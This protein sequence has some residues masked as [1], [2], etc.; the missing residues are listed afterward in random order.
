MLTFHTCAVP[1]LF[2]PE[3]AAFYEGYWAYKGVTINKGTVV[4]GFTTNDDGHVR[5]L[6][7]RRFPLHPVP[8]VKQETDMKHKKKTRCGENRIHSFLVECGLWHLRV[9]FGEQPVYP[10]TAEGSLDEAVA[11][12]QH[13]EIW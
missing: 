5:I 6:L 9:A 7:S 8:P 12:S 13:P 3:I 10:A 2:T 4:T 11:S 1:R